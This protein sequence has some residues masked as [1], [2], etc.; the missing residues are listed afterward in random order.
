MITQQQEDKQLS[1]RLANSLDKHLTKENTQM[2]KTQKRRCLGLWFIIEM[3]NKMRCPA[4]QS[5]QL[6]KVNT[7]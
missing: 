5:E 7:G 3:E 1:S 4:D 2:A 6:K